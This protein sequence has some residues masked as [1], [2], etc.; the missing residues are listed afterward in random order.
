M[1]KLSDALNTIRNT[2]TRGTP[3]LMHRALR[4]APLTWSSLLSILLLPLLFT[5]LIWTQLDG[6]MA[7]WMRIFD[8]WNTQMGMDNQ[9]GFTDINLFGRI[10]TITYPNV[11]V[12]GVSDVTAWLNIIVCIVLFAISLIFP[13]RVMPLTS[14]FRAALLIQTSASIYCFFSDYNFPYDTAGYLSGMLSLGGYLLFIISPLLALI[15]YIFNFSLLRKIVVTAG[16]LSYFIVM[17][18]FLYTL[19]AL[20]ISEWGMIFMPVLYLLFGPLLV[21]LMFISMYSYAM[22]RKRDKRES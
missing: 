3:I 18:P 1:T 5:A 21:T 11:P 14:L 4:N 8:F 16:I 19:H 22:T 12:D 13:K 15:Y 2:G 7:I 9:L 10:F 20:I 17:I 6:I